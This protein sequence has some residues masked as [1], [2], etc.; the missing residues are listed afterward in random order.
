MNF[1]NT[2]VKKVE[3]G[4]WRQLAAWIRCFGTKARY[5]KCSVFKGAVPAIREDDWLRLNDSEQLMCE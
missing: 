3:A 2:L 1:N 4:R 5:R